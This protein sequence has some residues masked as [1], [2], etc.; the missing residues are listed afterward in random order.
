MCPPLPLHSTNRASP[1]R[2]APPHL[3]SLQ[4]FPFA[5]VADPEVVVSH[6]PPNV[7]APRV[8]ASPQCCSMR[9]RLPTKQHK[10]FFRDRAALDHRFW[11]DAGGPPLR[12]QLTMSLATHDTGTALLRFLWYGVTG[13]GLSFLG[14][15]AVDRVPDRWSG[16]DYAGFAWAG[17]L[18]IQ[19]VAKGVVCG[20]VGAFTTASWSRVAIVS[21]ATAFALWARIRLVWTSRATVAVLL[22]CAGLF[23]LAP[24]VTVSWRR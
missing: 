1:R 22:G 19:C 2:A 5:T 12:P 16:G 17:L 20:A 15:L 7:L 14:F 13:A 11:V 6:H 23:F 8:A 21:F 9:L 4:V 3:A 18:M 10:I 24:F